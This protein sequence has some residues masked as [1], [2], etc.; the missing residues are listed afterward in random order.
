MAIRRCPYCKAIIDESQKYCNNCGTQLLFPEDEF[1]EEDIKGEKIVDEDF[2]DAEEELEES[3]EPS[4]EEEA[5]NEEIDL[6]EVL[7]G[8]AAFPGEDDEEETEDEAEEKVEEEVPE[9][10][11]VEKPKIKPAAA[12]LPASPAAAPVPIKAEPVKPAPAEAEPVKP[13]PVKPEPAKPAPPIPVPPKAEPMKPPPPKPASPK[14]EPAK[15]EEPVERKPRK[16]GRPQ[17]VVMTPVVEE[18]EVQALAADEPPDDVEDEAPLDEDLEP[19]EED[20]DKSDPDTRE[21]IVRLIAALEKKQK[22]LSL[23]RDEEKLLAPLEE[24][25]NIPPWADLSKSSAS[26]EIVDE[27]AEEKVESRSFVP[28]DTM[29]FEEEVMSRAEKIAPT[30]PTIGIP[31]KVTKDKSGFLF[32]KADIAKVKTDEI[33]IPRYKMEEAEEAEEDVYAAAEEPNEAEAAEIPRPRL[34]FFGRLTAFVFDL[35]FIAVVWMGTVWGASLMMDVPVRALV[36]AVPIPLGGLFL[37][38]LAGYFFL[39]FFFLGETL[40]GR[41]ASPRD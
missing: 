26:T 17:P 14:P 38:L 27:D 13:E 41:M 7:E 30:R 23:T 25:S 29:D 28:G 15:E 40:G 36:K 31:E 9:K 37:I 4:G 39:F 20:D 10:K 1:V 35:I 5:Q 19:D 24:A 32:D 21:E 18:R 12:P 2:K 33:G 3:V 11:P 16:K 34:G 22:K 6:E 8:E